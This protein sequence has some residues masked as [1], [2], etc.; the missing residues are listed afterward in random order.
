M[1]A[2][3]P[4]PATSP[5]PPAPAGT[6]A[7]TATAPTAPTAPAAGGPG[8]GRRGQRAARPE[9]PPRPPRPEPSAGNLAASTSL[10][11]LAVLCLWLLVHLLFLGTVSHDRA[12]ALLHSDFR[13]QLAG[14]TAPVGPVVPAGE[15]VALLRIPAIGVQEVVVEGTAAGDLFAGP[16]HRRN[17]VLPG[18]VGTSLVY[19]R[20]VTYGAPF[21]R[22][23]ELAPGDLVEVTTAQGK[24]NLRVLGVRRDGDPLPQPAASGAARLT[25]VTAAGEGRLAALSPGSALYVDAEV[26]QGHPA[27]GGV[28]AV[29]PPSEEAMAS[30]TEALPLLTLWL[31]CLIAVVAAALL[32]LQRW[33]AG[34]VWVVAVAPVLALAWLATDTAMRLLPNLV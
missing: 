26:P 30:G 31:T 10:T 33:S 4:P 15:P 19:G 27:P 17:T 22:L 11:V 7:P 5:V 23:A 32:A 12:Q 20:S 14:A 2:T 16:G 13:A 6:S 8:K 25:L 9:R 24:R 3:A 1:T 34:L 28:P 18:Q 21:E 29:V